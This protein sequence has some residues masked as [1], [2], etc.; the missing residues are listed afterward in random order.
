MATPY[1]I[2]SDLVSAYPAKSLEIAQYIDGFKA[3]LAL[4]QNAQTGTTYS[5][6]A[7]DFT[8]LVT[9]SNASPVAV[10][11]PLEA[12]VPWSAGTTA[13]TAQPRRRTVTVAGDVGVTING[14]PLTLAQYKGAIIKTGTTLGRSSLS[15]RLAADVLQRVVPRMLRRTGLHVR[16]YELHST[17]PRAHAMSWKLAAAAVTLRDQVNKRYPRRDRASDGTIG[18]LAHRRR[19]S[20]H[21]PDKTGYVM[22]LD[23]DEDGWPAHQFADQLIEYMRTSGDKRIKNVVY[24]GRVASGTYSNKLWVWRK[25]PAPRPRTT[26]TSV[27]PSPP[28]TTG[29]RSR[30]PSSMAPHW[31]RPRK[32]RQRRQPRR[33]R[34]RKRREEGDPEAMTEMFTT[35]IGLLIAVIGL[36]TLVI[37]GQAKAQRPNGGKSQYDLLLR[38]EG[39]LDRLERNQDEHLRHHLKE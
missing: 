5:F 27:S 34:P 14:T 33:P 17:G 25:R 16:R 4:V 38:I 35:V 28:S 22:A 3:D 9:L 2:S 12:T 36:V 39:R 13:A 18:N 37:R 21:N 19:I 30:S 11:L 8:K 10:T 23:L 7:A 1:V 20:D 29:R 31:C 26:S 24:E 32:R 6:V 15:G